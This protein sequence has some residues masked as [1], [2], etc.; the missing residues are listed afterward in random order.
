VTRLGREMG[1]PAYIAM[2]SEH[3]ATSLVYMGRFEEAYVRAQEGL[4]AARQIGDLEHEATLLALALPFIHIRNGDFEAARL[5]LNQALDISVKIGMLIA[6]VFAAHFLSKIAY[7]QGEYEAALRWGKQSLEVALPFENFASFLLVPVLGSLGMVYLDISE[8]F[9]DKVAEF[10]QH[11]LRLLEGPPGTMSGSTVWADLGHCA[12]ALGDLDLAEEVLQKGLNFPNI[13][14]LLERPRNLAGA[15][16]LACARGE[17]DE[18]VRLAEEARADAEEHGLRHLY[19]LTALIRGKVFAARGDH[20]EA[21]ASL[22]LAEQEAQELGMRPLVWQARAAAADVLTALG[23]ASQ[24]EEKRQAA[25]AMVGEIANL[26]EAQDL[27]AA[28][29]QNALSKIP[30]VA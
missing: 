1:N 24:A 13:F 21:F 23:Q 28:F 9:I 3:V 15:A 22:E 6:Q 30:K 29:L 27:R 5:S 20:N 16:L 25:Q 2:G 18:A 4:Q 17:F 14:Q 11:A 8:K 12:I 10:H 19:P 7:W 26:F